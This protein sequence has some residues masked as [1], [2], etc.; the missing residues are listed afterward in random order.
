MNNELLAIGGI[1]GVLFLL[2]GLWYW[3]RPEYKRYTSDTLYGANW[4]WEWQGH[5]I[6]GLW[7]YCPT[8]KGALSFDDTLCQTTHKLGEKTTYLICTHCDAGQVAQ[9]KG[10]D[11]R[12]VL[13]LVQREI[14]RRAQTKTFTLQK[15]NNE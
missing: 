4:Q 13:K 12:Y 11:R 2:V 9:I 3:S 1:V 5:S 15:G 7:C 8:C 10:G 6:I 14:L